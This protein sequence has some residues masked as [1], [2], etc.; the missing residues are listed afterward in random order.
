VLRIS[1][2]VLL[3]LLLIRHLPTPTTPLGRY[4]TRVTTHRGDIA[5]E[6]LNTPPG[7]PLQAALLVTTTAAATRAAEGQKIFSSVAAFLDKHRGQNTG[8]PLTSKMCLKLSAMT[9]L[10]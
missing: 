8:L 1:L 6:G 9:W 5:M 10:I 4:P 7:G 2:S 3:H